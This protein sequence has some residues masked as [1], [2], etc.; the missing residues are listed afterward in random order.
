MKGMRVN[1]GAAIRENKVISYAI[2]AIFGAAVVT[3]ATVKA[4][5]AMTTPSATYGC[6]IAD[7]A[8]SNLNNRITMI[9]ST[10]PDPSKYF[11]VGGV[12][13]C[14]GPVSNIDLSNLIPDPMG[15]LTSLAKE[16]MQVAVQKACTAA[17]Q[18]LSDYLGKYNMA[19]STINGGTQGMLSTALGQSVGLNLANYGTSYAAPAGTQVVVNPLATVTGA[20]NST[21]GAP[22]SSA[23]QGVTSAITSAT[24]PV[25][26]A[27]QGAM[28]SA[29]SAVAG[30]VT[31][32]QKGASSLGSS[33]FGSSN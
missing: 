12:S 7:A 13:S 3:V 6:A 19:A 16:A 23:Q 4:Q 1:V 33:V 24:A 9:G 32:I 18:S 21:V 8:T 25:T 20:V 27:Y 15:L 29:T 5:Q 22:L 28:S 26:S 31:S 30:G 10:A 2:G 17:R 14:I 11:T